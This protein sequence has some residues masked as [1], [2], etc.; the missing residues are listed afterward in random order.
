M[1]SAKPAAQGQVWLLV[2]SRSVG[3]VERHITILA[4]GLRRQGIDA[5]AVLYA[6]HGN[7]PWCAQ[8]HEAGVPLRFLDGTLKGLVKDLWRERPA[9]LHTHGYK[10]GV[11]GRIAGLLTGTRVVSTFHS[12]EEPPFPVNLYYRLDEWSSLTAHRIVVSEKIQRKV[13]YRSTLIPNYLALGERPRP[14]PFSRKVGFVGRLSHE[15]SPDLFCELARRSRPGLEWHVWGDG[16]MRADLEARYGDIVTFHGVVSDIWPI[17][18]ELGLLIMPSRYEGLPL[19]ALEA[20]SMGVP[21][22]ASRVGG[23][24]TVVLP[25]KTGWLVE[26]EDLDGALAAV[27]AWR[28][29]SDDAAIEMQANCWQHVADNFSEARMLPKILD[30]Y[31]DAGFAPDVLAR[32]APARP[33]PSNARG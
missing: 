15:K 29:L 16:A 5:I 2:D 21:V 25:G 32:P 1:S 10:A 4:Q 13:P 9:L 17:W 26:V 33:I 28:A 20:L 22:V 11:L 8:V 14:K 18:A 31:R 24:P 12:G 7:S 23:V 27:E 19:A 6:D 30:V 3:G